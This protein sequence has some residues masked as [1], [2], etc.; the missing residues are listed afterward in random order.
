MHFIFILQNYNNWDYLVYSVV[1]KDIS[2][3]ERSKTYSLQGI[4]KSDLSVRIVAYKV[5]ILK[6]YSIRFIPSASLWKEVIHS[7]EL[8]NNTVFTRSLKNSAKV[9][10][11][12][13]SSYT[14]Q[15]WQ[16]HCLLRAGLPDIIGVYSK[17]SVLQL[18]I[19][20][21]WEKIYCP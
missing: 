16:S 1:F 15:N 11:A 9:Y 8:K 19:F 6:K 5:T 2:Q 7:I 20:R 10:F 17:W 21:T 12:S 14:V 18:H 4:F 3:I 13:T